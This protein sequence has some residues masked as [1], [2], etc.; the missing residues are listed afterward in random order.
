MLDIDN[1]PTIQD[2]TEKND[3][4]LDQIYDECLDLIKHWNTVIKT[5]VKI[6]YQIINRNIYNRSANRSDDEYQ[7]SDDDAYYDMSNDQKSEINAVMSI[8]NKSKINV[9]LLKTFRTI[10]EQS[11]DNR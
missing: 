8:I 7:S 11:F 3:E 1:L 6:K 10:C 4:E 2:L 5:T 9:N